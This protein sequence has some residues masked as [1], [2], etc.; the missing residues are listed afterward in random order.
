MRSWFVKTLVPMLRE[1]EANL[2]SYPEKLTEEEWRSILLEMADLLETFNVWDDSIA[3][4]KAN[5]D[6]GDN[7]QDSYALIKA[8]QDRAKDRFFFLLNK[9]I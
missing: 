3:R 9:F 8:E 2:I 6:P 1:M 7:S 5:V 4:Q